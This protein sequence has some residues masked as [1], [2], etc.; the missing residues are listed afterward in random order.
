LTEDN[1]LLLANRKAKKLKSLRLHQSALRHTRAPYI[2]PTLF[3]SAPGFQYELSGAVCTGVY[4]RQETEQAGYLD[5]VTVLRGAT[6]ATG[7]SN[8]LPPQSIDP[9]LSRSTARALEQAGLRPSQRSRRF[10]DYQLEQLHSETDA[11]QD[12]QAS[13]IRFPRVKRRIR[14]YPHALHASE[15]VRIIAGDESHCRHPGCALGGH[16]AG[17]H[18]CAMRVYSAMTP[19]AS[20]RSSPPMSNAT[21]PFSMASPSR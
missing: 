6:D 13:H 10:A 19:L 20:S 11:Y 3:L 1:P 12:R 4:L 16:A 2:E 15:A 5:I 17:R 18:G 9:Q 14:L 8:N 21:C 7:R